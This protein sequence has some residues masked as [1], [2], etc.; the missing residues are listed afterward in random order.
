MSPNLRNE[1]CYSLEV[2]DFNESLT[3]DLTAFFF[4][5]FFL[6][7]F[8]LTYLLT[9]FK[10]IFPLTHNYF[11]AKFFQI[12]FPQEFLLNTTVSQLWYHP[13]LRSKQR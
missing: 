11:D 4:F 8:E 5:A 13:A 2:S 6:I 7:P 9:R 1:L 10:C 3:Q 12:R